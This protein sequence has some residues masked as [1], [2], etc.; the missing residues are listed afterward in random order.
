MM[1]GINYVNTM[2]TK[3]YAYVV[4]KKGVENKCKFCYFNANASNIYYKVLLKVLG[5]FYNAYF[6]YLMGQESFSK[7]LAF[8]RWA[9]ILTLFFSAFFLPFH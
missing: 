5:L 8:G 4:K 6:L 2:T 9:L 1:V 7:K 3:L